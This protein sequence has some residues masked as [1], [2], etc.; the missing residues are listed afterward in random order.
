MCFEQTPFNLKIKTN[1]Y[2]RIWVLYVLSIQYYSLASSFQICLRDYIEKLRLNMICHDISE[3]K[4]G[5]FFF[6]QC[7]QWIFP[8]FPFFNGYFWRKKPTNFLQL[9]FWS[10]KQI[11]LKSMWESWSMTLHSCKY[12]LRPVVSLRLTQGHY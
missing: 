6:Q 11:F 7:C 2:I 4:C 5:G 3:K 1:R 12:F 10:K 9:T 8:Q